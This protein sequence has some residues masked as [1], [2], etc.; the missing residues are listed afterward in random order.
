MNRLLRLHRKKILGFAIVAVLASPLLAAGTFTDYS[1]SHVNVV[2]RSLCLAGDARGSISGPCLTRL[3]STSITFPGCPVHASSRPSGAG[4]YACPVAASSVY[5]RFTGTAGSLDIF[6]TTASKGKLRFTA[7]DSAGDTTTA[8]VN[9]SQTGAR[10]YTIPDAGASASFVMTEGA[11]TVNG[12]K[13]IPAITTTNIDAGA[14]A[15]AGTVD[16]F[17]TTAAKGKPL[18][19]G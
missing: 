5:T 4:Q 8:I 19:M 15:T 16:V 1:K 7:A 3:S 11:Q 2:V 12:L 9:A 10:T 14:S 6:P 17:P 18:P 13:T